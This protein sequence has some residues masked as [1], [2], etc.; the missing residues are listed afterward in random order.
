MKKIV[1]IT[2]IYASICIA[3][4]TNTVIEVYPEQ[5]TPEIVQP[6]AVQ[7]GEDM[8]GQIISDVYN[9]VSNDTG[10]ITVEPQQL[11]NIVIFLR[12]LLNTAIEKIDEKI[13]TLAASQNK[14]E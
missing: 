10:I 13:N 6:T 7:A 9:K 1:I 2:F 12:D 11:K 8:K 14:P 5:T 4:E 3:N